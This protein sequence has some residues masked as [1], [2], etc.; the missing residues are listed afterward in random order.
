[1]QL[2]RLLQ[3][4]GFGSRKVCRALIR[5]EAVSVRGQPCDDPFLECD[6]EGLEFS[7]DGQPWR[8][9]EKAYLML[10]KPTG[11]ECSRAPRDHPGV[12]SLLPSPLLTRGVQPVGRLD[13]DTTGLLLLSDDGVFIHNLIAPKRKVAKVYEVHAKHPMADEQLAA[14][15]TGVLLHDATEPVAASAC[16]RISERVFLLTVTEGRYHQVKRMVAAA[17]NRVED[18]RRV[19]VGGL[20]LPDDLPAGEWRWLETA[21]L[22]RLADG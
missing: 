21:D 16:E 13:E 7:V 17:G 6:P 14:L 8:Y 3:S 20:K 11:Y 9:R 12:L 19:Q 2:E 22:A 10:H 5:A 1:M 15:R 4:Q 18:L